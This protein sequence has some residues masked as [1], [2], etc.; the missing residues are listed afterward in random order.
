MALAE[1]K[2]KEEAEAEAAGKA[3]DCIMFSLIPRLG[4]D[5]S[6]E[7]GGADGERNVESSPVLT[8]VGDLKS[9]E[10]LV[11]AVGVNPVERRITVVFRGSVT[12]NDFMTDAKIR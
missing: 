6:E 3:N 7:S 2:K 8:V 12:T 1:E 9:N 11:Y 5:S 10:E 4:D